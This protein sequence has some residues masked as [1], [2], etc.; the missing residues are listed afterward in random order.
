MWSRGNHKLRNLREAVVARIS[1][2]SAIWPE[3]ILLECINV[4]QFR[5]SHMKMWTIYSRA[6]TKEHVWEE[7]TR[8]TQTGP[9]HPSPPEQHSTQDRWYLEERTHQP[10]FRV[11]VNTTKMLSHAAWLCGV[12]CSCGVL[13]DAKVKFSHDWNYLNRALLHVGAI[14][15]CN[16]VLRQRNSN[17]L[18]FCQ[19]RSRKQTVSVP[20]SLQLGITLL[21]YQQRSKT[22]SNYHWSHSYVGHVHV[23]LVTT[24]KRERNDD[25]TQE[26]AR[27]RSQTR[28]PLFDTCDMD[29]SF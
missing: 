12:E 17:R 8:E 29:D 11:C 3:P 22:R 10:A 6:K 14:Y 28:K 18:Q 15:F 19:L 24:L 27:Q 9:T 25:S 13:I 5:Q 21:A 16:A 20:V 26:R 4:P 23:G 2:F 7:E 1:S